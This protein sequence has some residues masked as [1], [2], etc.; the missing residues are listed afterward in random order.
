M[1]KHHKDDMLHAENIEKGSHVSNVPADKNTPAVLVLAD[2]KVFRG[3]GFGAT[4]T[5]LG[6]AVF[7]TAMT[8]YQE[9]LTDPSYHRQIIVATP[10]QI[11]NT[12][13]ND[14]DSESRDGR[15]WAAG[16]VIRD[17]SRAPSNWR[18]KRTLVDEM[19][20]Q[21]LIGIRQIDTRAL[22]RHIRDHGSIAAGIFS[23]D[24]AAKPVDEL[25]EIVRAQPSMAGANLSEEVT[26]GETY[27]IEPDGEPTATVVA[28]DLG[29]KANTPRELAK[30]G[31][32]VV[33]VPA[34]TPYPQIKKDHDPDGV[35]IS[36]GPGDPATADAM[37]QVAKN[38]LDDG[39]PLFGICFGNQILG[40]ALGLNTYKMRFGHRGI[41]VPVKDHVTGTIYITAQNHGFALEGTAGESFDTPWGPARVTHTC[42][43]DDTVEGVALESGM[44]FSVQY[45]P[46]S[47]AGPHDAHNLFDDF[48]ALMDRAG[49][50]NQE[51]QN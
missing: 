13:W 42:L 23:G 27:V 7:T 21:G 12:G 38:A 37:V 9:T 36:N 4:G 51:G 11:G 30:R 32:K 16:Y 2:G 33:V 49:S 43:N 44:A 5:T 25:V 3:R 22:V 14:E 15:I 48:M 39:M 35:F 34:N 8:G 26:A 50:N 10:P 28:Y 40:R 45:H 19:V 31:A 18:S 6:E 17:L 1:G 47:A 29:I 41:N 20:A 24:A 46:E